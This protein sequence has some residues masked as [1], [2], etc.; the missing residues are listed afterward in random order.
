VLSKC[1]LTK[2]VGLGHPRRR[3]PQTA[4]EEHSGTSSLWPCPTAVQCFFFFVVVV[5]GFELR[6]LHLLGVTTT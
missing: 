4:K 1:L 5:L 6:S 2:R 3:K